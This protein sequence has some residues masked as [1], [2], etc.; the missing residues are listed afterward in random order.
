MVEVVGQIALCLQRR[1]E[2]GEE[3]FVSGIVAAHRASLY[4]VGVI[5][6]LLA[7]AP[8]PDADSGDPDRSWVDAGWCLGLDAAHDGRALVPIDADGD[9][10]LDVALWALAGLVYYENVGEA[11]DWTR[12]RLEPAGRKTSAA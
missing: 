5:G 7:C 3:A 12:V 9:G 11:R 4:P 2:Q 10:D 6:I 8:P 1:A